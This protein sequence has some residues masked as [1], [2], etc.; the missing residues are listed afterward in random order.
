MERK[1]K[2]EYTVKYVGETG[3]SGYERGSEHLSDFLNF[4]EGSHL[5]KHYLNCHQDLKMSDVKFGMRVRQSFRSALDRQIGEAVAIDV[6]RRKGKQLMNSKSEYNRCTIP[7]ITTKSMKET[8]EEN[9]KE[10]ENEKKMKSQIKELKNERKK[11]RYKM[12]D[13]KFIRKE[14]IDGTTED[15]NLL[16]DEKK[17]DENERKKR[18]KDEINVDEMVNIGKYDENP[19]IDEKKK[20]EKNEKIDEMEN[21]QETSIPDKNSENMPKAVQKSPKLGLKFEKMGCFGIKVP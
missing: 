5:L 12:R 1:T 9:E 21:D 6:E 2:K 15:E 3:R 14:N 4:E 19:S 8:V 17:V 18:R 13:E 11:K 7:R 20:S 10:L 16:K